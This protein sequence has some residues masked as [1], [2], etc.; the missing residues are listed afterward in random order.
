M[1]TF[2]LACPALIQQPQIGHPLGD[3]FHNSMIG[4]ANSDF[5][6][7]QFCTS[8]SWRH[9]RWPPRPLVRRPC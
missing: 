4:K 7:G 5:V 8:L 1:R 2:F 9:L 3:Q 6:P